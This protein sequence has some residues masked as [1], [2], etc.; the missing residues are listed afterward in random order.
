[1]YSGAKNLRTSFA[2]SL[3]FGLSLTLMG[4]GGDSPPPATPKTNVEPAPK[5]PLTK[6]EIKKKFLEDE[7]TAAQ[8]RNARLKEQK[9][10]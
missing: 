1:M 2:F 7:P 10:N 3:I 8:K 5:K 9:G 4:C 6:S